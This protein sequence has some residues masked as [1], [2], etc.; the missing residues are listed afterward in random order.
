MQT[1]TLIFGLVLAFASAVPAARN[2]P[3]NA[4]LLSQVKT[5]TLRDGQQTSGRRVSP[6]PQLTCV[7]GSG[8][9]F[10]DVDVMRCKNAGAE[11]DAEDVQWTC[12]AALP[13][14]FKLGGTEV[15]C[16]G[17]DSPDD[18][19]IL[20]GSCGVEYRLV[21]TEAGEEK[22]GRNSF[23][24]AYKHPS[25]Q[26]VGSALFTLIFWAV[27]ISIVCVILYRIFWPNTGNDR[28]GLGNG[29]GIGWNGGGGGGGGDDDDDAPP[30]YSPSN[31][32]PS[33]SHHANRAAPNYS[34]GSTHGQQADGTWRPGFWTG[35]AAGAAAGYAAS[36][37]GGRNAANTAN[38][39]QQN[40]DSPQAGPSGWFG[41]TRDPSPP[42]S[43]PFGGG[44]S[45][46]GGG[47]G[48]A[49]GSS[50]PSSSSQP[51]SSRHESTGFGGTRR[52]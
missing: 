5:L 13:P 25:G 30:P 18:P 46:F 41:R 14:E 24:R 40:Y 49:G 19:Y 20:K 23:E 3:A 43:S 7:G 31:P 9:G 47:A 33:S 12:Q 48:G 50:R 44:S 34:A 15:V 45:Y 21:L 10:Y 28:R 8:K 35:T 26:S 36:A 11:Y 1:F 29:N 37:L 17:Y 39:P 16:E 6:M 52:R 38:R 51:S 2:K 4:V 42:R 32:K 27:F 22:F